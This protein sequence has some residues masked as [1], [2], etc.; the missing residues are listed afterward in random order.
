MFGR[1]LIDAVPAL[2]NCAVPRKWRSVQYVAA[3]SQKLT[4]PLVTAADPDATV[5]VRFTK[6]P[7]ATVVV[8]LP[9]EDT[10]SAVVVAAIAGSV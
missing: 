10:D 5:A 8:G 3:A 2:V 7:E 1:R 6:L 4:V 9:P